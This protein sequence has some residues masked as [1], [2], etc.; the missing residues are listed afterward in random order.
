[1][2]SRRPLAASQSL[3]VLSPLPDAM[4]AP[5]GENAT[6]ITASEWPSKVRSRR[7]LAASQSLIVLSSLPDAMR[8]PSGEN[9]TEFTSSLMPLESAQQP[10]ARRVPELD[11]TH[12]QLPDAMRAPSGENFDGIDHGKIIDLRNELRALG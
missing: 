6:D 10:A 3:I 8:A 2:R 11:R 12:P 1:M 5:S 7:P 4:R 9:A